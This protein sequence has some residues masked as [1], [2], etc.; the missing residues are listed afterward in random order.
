MWCFMCWILWGLWTHNEW[1][2]SYLCGWRRTSQPLLKSLWYVLIN[3]LT[4]YNTRLRR[5]FHFLLFT[6][7]YFWN[8][9]LTWQ[10]YLEWNV[11]MCTTDSDQDGATNGDEMGDPCCVWA[12]G[13]DPSRDTQL[14]NPAQKDASFSLPS[15]TLLGG[16]SVLYFIYLLI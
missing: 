8:V 9:G 2:I 3:I 5:W 12:A 15:C 7:S 6:I 10:I 4:R 11:G 13:S 14:S 16:N 1:W